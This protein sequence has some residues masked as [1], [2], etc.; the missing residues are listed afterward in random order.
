MLEGGILG[1]VVMI[2]P[3]IGKIL[4]MIPFVPNK[5]IPWVNR[6][7]ASA[8]NY[9]ALLGFGELGVVPNDDVALAGMFGG[10]VGKIAEVGIAVG[11][12]Y[13]QERFAT[14]FYE[15]SRAMAKIGKTV[16]WWEK[17]KA[18]IWKK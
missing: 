14:R 16:S 8:A 3:L 13:V 6:I 9:W 11:L 15:G 7:V 2:L 1:L 10:I 5:M 12:G 18:D 17:G 4:L